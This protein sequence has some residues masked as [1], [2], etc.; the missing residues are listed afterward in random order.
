MLWIIILGGMAAI[1]AVA[2]FKPEW[3]D[4]IWESTFK[5]MWVG[6]VGIFL[7]V[8]N[9]LNVDPTWQQLVPS[10]YVP[11]ALVGMAVFGIVLSQ[12]NRDRI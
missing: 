1:W 3:F 12:I 8:I 6:F 5:D 9:Y 2:Y 4:R 10:E 11:W 7:A